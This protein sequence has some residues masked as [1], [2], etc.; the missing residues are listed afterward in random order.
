[1][2][3]I[4]VLKVMGATG[5]LTSTVRFSPPL[6]SSVLAKR[7]SSVLKVRLLAREKLLGSAQS[8]PLICWIWNWVLSRPGRKALKLPLAEGAVTKL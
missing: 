1:M 2:A 7:P 3:L 8:G 5:V 6:I 4:P